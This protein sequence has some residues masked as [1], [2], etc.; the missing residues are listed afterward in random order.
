MTIATLPVLDPESGLRAYLS[1]I[2]KFPILSAD[3]EF[4][5]AV[6]VAT[7]HD[8][9]AAH[10]LVTSHL[11]LVAKIAIGYRGYGLP[12]ADL[13]SEGTIGM[14]QAVK[15]FDPYKGFRLST[16][17]L[18]W[19]K[20]SIQEYVLKSWSLVKIATTAGQ[21]KLFFNLKKIKQTLKVMDEKALSDDQIQHISQEYDISTKDIT[22][23]DQRLMGSDLSLNQPVSTA[24]SDSSQWQDQL[25]KDNQPTQEHLLLESDESRYRRVLMH[26]ALASLNDREK[27]ILTK[28]RLLETPV[29]LQT[30]SEE[31]GVSKERVRQ[32]EDQAFKR[33]Q[34]F[35]TGTLAKNQP[36]PPH[37]N[38]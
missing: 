35:I 9:D 25:S 4:D 14:M 38:A 12:V 31:H 17:A 11:R 24:E 20:A 8:R 1:E 2:N 15:K 18:W 19:I 27:D 13:I 23:M 7:N 28:R 6:K 21:K 29:T 33:L 26:K 22:T 32:L 36:M 16:Y 30:L 5:L 34:A 3:Q 10:T 37:A